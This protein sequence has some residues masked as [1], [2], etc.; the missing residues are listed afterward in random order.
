MKIVIFNFMLL[1]FF[2]SGLFSQNER[3]ICFSIEEA[4]K[5]PEQVSEL[6]LYDNYQNK[7]L[8]KEIR[9]LVNL[10]VLNIQSNPLETLPPEIG[11]LKKLK[12]IYV[13]ETKLK[14]L[15][16]EIGEL[17]NLEIL[18]LS[19]NAIITLPAEIGRLE[20]LTTLYIAEKISAIPDEI[21][22]CKKLKKID[23]YG[24]DLSIAEQEKLTRF[25]PDIEELNLPDVLEG[26]GR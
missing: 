18:N 13:S 25:F 21:K 12:A 24:T 5:T 6:H 7:S 9:R 3:K 15:P 4:L 26:Q 17:K 1:L 8:P 22:N 11:Q 19:M 23:V 2:I 10:E 14:G 20:N 16:K